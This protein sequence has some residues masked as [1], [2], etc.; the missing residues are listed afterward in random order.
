MK[1]ANNVL[2]G[3]MVGNIVMF[4]LS[5]AAIYSGFSVINSSSRIF[6]ASSDLITGAD[7]NSV[8]DG[9]GVLGGMAGWVGGALIAIIGMALI[10]VGVV[11]MVLYGV[12]MVLSIV[13]KITA[14][15]TYA[16]DIEKCRKKMMIAGIVSTV[17][18]GIVLLAV[19][20]CLLGAGG[21]VYAI[22][23]LTCLVG[24]TLAFSIMEIVFTQKKQWYA[25]STVDK[26]AYED[27]E[28]R[29]V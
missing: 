21:I 23:I 6:D 28:T 9:W 14:N 19:F 5:I 18:N 10:F 15:K 13:T 29:N 22:V 24:A 26:Q 25:I 27:V 4:I 20:F 11:A 7:P 17:M 1:K 12:A 8:V 16:L 2:T 3:M